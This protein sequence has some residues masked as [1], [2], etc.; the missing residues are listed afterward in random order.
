MS[1]GLSVD[2]QEIV[3]IA[4]QGDSFVVPRRLQSVLTT[5]DKT[6]CLGLFQEERQY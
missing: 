2:G 1:G 4:Q 5:C 6:P 3:R